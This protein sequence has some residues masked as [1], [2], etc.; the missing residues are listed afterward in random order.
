[1]GARAAGRVS[2]PRGF[3]GR[4][5][6][7]ERLGALEGQLDPLGLEETAATPAGCARE[8]L[9]PASVRKSA[10]RPCRQGPL[11]RRA[12]TTGQSALATRFG[13]ELLPR[14]AEGATDLS[15]LALELGFSSHRHLSDARGVE[16]APGA[17]LPWL[18]TRRRRQRSC[19]ALRTRGS[20]I[21][22]RS[23]LPRATA[24]RLRARR[25]LPCRAARG[26]RARWRMAG[27]RGE[28]TRRRRWRLRRLHLDRDSAGTL[29]RRA[30]SHLRHR[31]RPKR[32]RREPERVRRHARRG[33]SAQHELALLALSRLGPLQVEYQAAANPYWTSLWI[34]AP[35]VPVTRVEVRSASHSSYCFTGSE[36]AASGAP[37]PRP[38]HPGERAAGTAGTRRV[39][40]R[41][42]RHERSSSVSAT[43][44]RVGSGS[45]CV[46][47]WHVGC[48]GA[49]WATSTP[50]RPRAPP[51][52]GGR[53]EPHR[54]GMHV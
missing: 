33:I 35:R 23:T 5:R 16:T 10:P 36:P 53:A 43:D 24:Q 17:A 18:Q 25:R 12:G 44:A 8:R 13:E 48:F 34:R 31:A 6:G 51:A 52:G 41:A 54:G 26:D 40:N 50:E 3:Y 47:R 32:H 2:A 19:S 4:G 22:G 7:R 39:R 11:A 30:R 42:P 21:S 38:R 9:R 28:R 15:A 45:G 29:D 37:R 46:P 27:G 20:T 49:V 14:L 1:M